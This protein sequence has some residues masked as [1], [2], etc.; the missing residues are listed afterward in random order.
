MERLF[1]RVQ[2]GE[3][4]EHPILQSNFIQVYPDVDIDNLPSGFAEFERKVYQPFGPYQVETGEDYVLENGKYVNCFLTKEMTEEEKTQKQESVK[5]TLES[6]YGDITSWTLDVDNC[7]WV[8]PTP[9]PDD[10]NGYR[11]DESTTSWV[12]V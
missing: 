12:Q 8:P 4:V 10:G 1:V 3:V 11:W 2:D 9:Y 7:E 5:Q 6:V